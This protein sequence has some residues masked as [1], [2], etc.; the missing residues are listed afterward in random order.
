M[1]DHSARPSAPASSARLAALHTLCSEDY[2]KGQSQRAT[3]ACQLPSY[4]A[5]ATGAVI[6]PPPEPT[7][8]EVAISVGQQ[9]LDSDEL[10]SVREALR[11]LLRALDAEPAATPPAPE[12]PAPR[13][14]AAHPDDPTPCTGPVVVT[15][16]N[17]GNAGAHGC[18]H[19]G[20][21]LLASLKDG[22]VYAL[23]T[24]PQAAAI[25]VFK[26]ADST[27]P[28]PWVD[29]PRTRDD[30]LSRNEIR[31]RGAR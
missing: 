1:T 27:R 21:R 3:A 18:E 13:C 7:D 11:L 12:P 22:R 16:L 20:A 19:H 28:F 10:L 25:R 9:L 15:I 31:E 14:P 8:L 23:G 30:Q 17:E 26:A 6:T 4:A 2:A 5:F 29:G 24:S